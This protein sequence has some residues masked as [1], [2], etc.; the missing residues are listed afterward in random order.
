MDAYIVLDLETTGLSPQQD[1]ILEIGALKVEED[2]I[3]DRYQTLINPDLQIPY[4]VQRL[5]GITQAM[6][7]QGENRKR[8]SATFWISAGICRF[9]AIIFCSITV[10]CAVK[11]R[12]W[13]G[14]LKK[15]G[16]IL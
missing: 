12:R 4:A 15:Q 7:E 14:T 9:W 2:R 11:R 6:A 10:L 8:E 3:T 16:R 1:R 5:T 13:D